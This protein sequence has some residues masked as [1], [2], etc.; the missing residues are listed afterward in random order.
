MPLE[1]RR[2]KALLKG[3]LHHLNNLKPIARL[4]LTYSDPP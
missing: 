2:R 1:R 3:R 4:A